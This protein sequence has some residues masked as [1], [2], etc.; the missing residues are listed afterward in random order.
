LFGRSHKG[1]KHGERV[2]SS[3]HFHHRAGGSAQY[4]GRAGRRE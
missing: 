4:L 3:Q 1:V 2:G